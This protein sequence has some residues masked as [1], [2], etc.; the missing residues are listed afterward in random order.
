MRYRKLTADN[1]YSFG[2]GQLDFWQNVPEAVGQSVLTRLLLWLGE[3]YLDT[4][5]GT[6]YIQGV[7]GKHSLQQADTTIQ[8]RIL[9]STDDQGVPTV[10]DIVSYQSELDPDNR[11]MSAETRIDTVYGPTAVQIANYALY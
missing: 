1:D 9:D 4:T 10:T 11:A 2:N 6:P 5:Q 3:W 8:Q 7:L